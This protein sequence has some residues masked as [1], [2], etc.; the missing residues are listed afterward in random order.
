MYA[1]G[2][3]ALSVSLLIALVGA[4]GRFGFGAD[5]D[6]HMIDSATTLSS[7]AL[8]ALD[9]ADTPTDGNTTSVVDSNLASANVMF[10]TSRAYPVEAI[11]GIVGADNLCAVHASEGGLPG[12][13]VAWLS[14]MIT[15]AVD[16]VGSARGWIRPD[17][18]PIVDVI[19]DSVMYYPPT[20]D[21]HGVRVV[22]IGERLG[23]LRV[24]TGTTDGGQLQG[25]TCG[26]WTDSSAMPNVATYGAPT[27]TLRQWTSHTITACINTDRLYCLGTGHTLGLPPIVPRSG[28]IA[29]VIATATL[30]GG[31]ADA[32]NQC[33]SAAQA[34]KLVGAYRAL[35][36]TTTDSAASRFNATGPT[37]VRI[38]GIPIADTAADLLAGRLSAP[39]NVN[40]NGSYQS[41]R[42]WTGSNRPDAMGS[43]TCLDWTS[44][45]SDDEAWTGRTNDSSL[46]FWHGALQR[47]NAPRSL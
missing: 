31:L 14:T 44:T 43:E 38:D 41:G 40:A 17:G 20:L 26:D 11:G 23:N 1:L 4:C 33:Q 34:A 5:N 9:A 21:E 2:V 6:T 15:H 12:Q 32:D 28:R 47:C 22:A 10:V 42:A 27:F 19:T 37:W 25:S 7:D 45:S 24:Y 13:Y 35:L 16:R 36:S 8:G 46:G 39:L 18:L 30:T 3:C 29:F